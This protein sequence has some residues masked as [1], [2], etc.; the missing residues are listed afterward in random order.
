MKIIIYI[1]ILLMLSI[2]SSFAGLLS[3]GESNTVNK[4][5]DIT[6]TINT[7][8]SI[9]KESVIKPISSNNGDVQE[10]FC[11]KYLLV[12]GL[13]WIKDTPS[14]VVRSTNKIIAETYLNTYGQNYFDELNKN[15]TKDT[16]ITK[17]ALIYSP[18]YK[19]ERQELESNCL[20]YR[21]VK[22]EQSDNVDMIYKQV[23]FFSNYY[24]SYPENL[25]KGVMPSFFIVLI[26]MTNTLA[27]YLVWLTLLNILFHVFTYIHKKDNVKIKRI[28]NA[29]LYF[30]LVWI[31]KLGLFWTIITAIGYQGVDMLSFFFTI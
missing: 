19:K 29:F 31:I 21:K 4:G 30:F 28:K 22:V 15:K 3:P 13:T 6:K 2:Q 17:K 12:K 27:F 10:I 24:A 5:I 1:I 18:L 7:T 8:T 9:T 23:R 14:S 11:D 26:D 20:D 25:K 16:K